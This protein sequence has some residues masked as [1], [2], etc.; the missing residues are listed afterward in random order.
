MRLPAVIVSFRPPALGN[1]WDLPNK[2]RPLALVSW[3]C[4]LPHEGEKHIWEISDGDGSTFA[5]RA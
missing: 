3:C 5:Q 1:C 4:T 2:H